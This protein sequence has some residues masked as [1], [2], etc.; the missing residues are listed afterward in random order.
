M[1][2]WKLIGYDPNTGNYINGKL[3]SQGL[4]FSDSKPIGDYE[5]ITSI[6]NWFLYYKYNYEYMQGRNIIWSLLLPIVGGDFS[7]WA[8]LTNEEKKV[9]SV[10]S[11]A[12]Y[13]LR[14]QSI[15]DEQ[16]YY[17]FGIQLSETSGIEKNILKGRQRVIEEMRFHVGNTVFRKEI[18]TK[19]NV[20]DFFKSVEDLIPRYISSNDPSFKYWLNNT[21]GTTYENNGFQQKSYYI[22]DLKNELNSI[23]NGNF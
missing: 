13:G 5:D 12:P 2:I 16:D 20:D 8:N 19:D 21:A 10:M 6:T 18:Y 1:K 23:Y 14:L 17:Y 22:E 9:A 15:T 7:G 11:L 3:P 4:I